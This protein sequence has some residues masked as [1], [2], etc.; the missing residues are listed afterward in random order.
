M[1]YRVLST[2]VALMFCCTA[3]AQA[4]LESQDQKFSYAIGFQVGNQ[5]NQRFQQEGLDVDST[6]FLQAVKDVLEQTESALSQ[7]DMQ[8]AFQARMAALQAEQN[9]AGEKNAEAGK[10]YRTANK[11]KEGVT[12]TE[13]GLQYRVIEKGEG[14]SPT[15]EDTVIVHYKGTLINGEE[16][17]SS[18][19]RGNPAT[20]SLG[21]IIP[22][23]QE[24]LA[25]MK[26]GSKWELV[27]PPELAYGPNGAGGSIGPNETLVFEV[28]LIEIQ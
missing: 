8:A 22:G 1:T 28:E 25:L 3:L 24:A 19:A 16:F 21:G 17:D 15:A 6:A 26:E 13:S 23:W 4:E 7:E 10:A 2:L 27:V 11:D 20:F 14:K 9:Q 18:Y 5:L 12:Q